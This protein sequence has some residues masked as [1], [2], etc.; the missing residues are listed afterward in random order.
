VTSFADPS[1]HQHRALH[2]FVRSPPQGRNGVG[3]PPVET[4]IADQVDSLVE[5]TSPG[6]D[7]L[8]R[9]LQGRPTVLSGFDGINSI[10]L[11]EASPIGPDLIVELVAAGAGPAG[12]HEYMSPARS[13]KRAVMR[14][15]RIPSPSIEARMASGREAGEKPSIDPATLRAQPVDRQDHDAVFCWSLRHASAFG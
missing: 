12:Q 14:P 10:D 11:Q 7:D 3:P 2:T 6:L 1:R 8:S 5:S 15:G 13:R 4:A 9:Q